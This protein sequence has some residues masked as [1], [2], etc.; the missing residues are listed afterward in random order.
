MFLQGLVRKVLGLGGGK[1]CAGEGFGLGLESAAMGEARREWLRMF[2]G[3]A[4]GKGQ[5]TRFAV[6]LTAYVATLATAELELN[7]GAGARADYLRGQLER[8]ALCGLRNAV[9]LAAAGGW[10]ALK[11]YVEGRDILCDVAPADGF[12]VTRMRGGQPLDAVFLDEAAVDGGEYLRFERHELLEAG[13]RVTNTAYARGRLGT[14]REVSLSTV[15]RWA[16][17]A[18]EV[19]IAGVREPLFSVLRM[20]FANTLEPGSPLPVALY[21]PAMGSLRELDRIY[22]EFLWEVKSG[23]RKQILDITAVAPGMG[24]EGRYMTGDQYLMLDMGGSAPKPYDDYSPEMR[25]EAYRQ[26][27]GVQL[28]LL[29]SQCQLSAESFSFEPKSG[30][31][32]TATEVMS[33]DHGTYHTVKA[34]QRDGLMPGL[35]ALGRIYDTYAT[36]YRLA[37]AGKAEISLS[38]GDAVFEDTGV[39][40]ERRKALADAGYLRPELLT[41]WYF[42]V[43]EEEGRRMGAGLVSG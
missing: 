40:F 6:A 43:G 21:A 4:E 41:G 16:H 18:P 29:E 14:G 2:Y 23:R 35:L 9:Q 28:R 1:A 42:G 24:D 19:M 11:P 13:L 3:Q 12:W 39:E 38:F 34:I 36:L 10:V 17:L 37:P 22:A 26:A 20:P 32:L 25:V 15:P 7:C 27:L 8:Y 30:Q 33:R 31:A 5:T